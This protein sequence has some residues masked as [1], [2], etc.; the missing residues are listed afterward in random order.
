MLVGYGDCLAD[1][2]H[3]IIEDG[4]FLLY[5]HATRHVANRRVNVWSPCDIDAL[6]ITLKLDFLTIDPL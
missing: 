1:A 2:P 6:A 5:L 3:R 4:Q